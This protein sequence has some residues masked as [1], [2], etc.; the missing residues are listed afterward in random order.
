MFDVN[1]KNKFAILNHFTKPTGSIAQ[2]NEQINHLTSQLDV[3]LKYTNQKLS[4]WSA[5]PNRIRSVHFHSTN[6]I[7]LITR[8]LVQNPMWFWRKLCWKRKSYSILAT[9]TTS[10]VPGSLFYISDRSTSV[11]FLIDAGAPFL[12]VNT[13]CVLLAPLDKQSSVS[14]SKPKVKNE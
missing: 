12:Q 2:C 13:I 11:G 7:V 4:P 5:R 10:P 1:S 6:P 8:I 14:Q 3:V 9:A